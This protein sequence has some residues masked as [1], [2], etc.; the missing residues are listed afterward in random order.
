EETDRVQGAV[1][2]VAR[3]LARG[4]AVEAPAR[5]VIDLL[6]LVQLQHLRLRAELL[7]RLRAVHPDVFGKYDH[8]GSPP[9]D[10]SAEHASGDKDSVAPEMHL[11]HTQ[12]CHIRPPEDSIVP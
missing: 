2:L 5:Q 12:T 3:C 10:G 6:D 11:W 8:V 7:R 9:G 4:G 1:G